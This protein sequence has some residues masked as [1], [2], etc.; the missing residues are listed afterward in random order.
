VGEGFAVL[1]SLSYVHYLPRDNTGKSQLADAEL[2]TRRADGGG[3][4]N[5]S[6][7][8][9]QLALEKRF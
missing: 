1:G 3:K 6:L 8:L 5:L 9:L 7:A 4:Y 2:P